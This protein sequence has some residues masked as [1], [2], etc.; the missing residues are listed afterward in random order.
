MEIN[1]LGNDE[2]PDPGD[3]IEVVE[4]DSG[5]SDGTATI[6]GGGRF[7]A[8]VPDDDFVGNDSFEYTVADENG[9]EDTCSVDITVE[10]TAPTCDDDI[11][12][13]TVNSVIESFDVL[14]NDADPDPGDSITIASVQSIRI[15]ADQL[16]S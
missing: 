5:P 10:N 6:I 7:V 11:Q 15:K 13:T 16:L 12:Q 14:T 8:Y 2:D 1:V 9:G 4:I 3:D